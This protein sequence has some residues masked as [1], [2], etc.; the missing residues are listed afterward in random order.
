MIWFFE[1]KGEHLRC[2]IRSQVEGDRYDLVITR[3]DGTESTERFSDS[4][5]LN[6]RVTEVERSLKGDGWDGPFA[7]DW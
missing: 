3:P 4:K 6:R 7:R 2:E 1:R 5:E